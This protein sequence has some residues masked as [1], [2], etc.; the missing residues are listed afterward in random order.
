MADPAYPHGIFAQVVLEAANGIPRDGIVN[1]FHFSGGANPTTSDMDD[2]ATLLQSFYNTSHMT[3]E[4]A[5]AGW[6]SV[7]LSRGTNKAHV[8][9]YNMG[10]AHP[11]QPHTV[12][13]TLLAASSSD[14]GLPAEVSVCLS[15]Q[16]NANHTKS[17]RG[18]VYIGPLHSNT[19][20]I[21]SNRVFPAGDTIESIRGAARF[22]IDAGTD[23][24]HPFHWSIY[25]RKLNEMFR[26]DA[27]YVDNEFDTQ[28]RRGYRP[29][30][31]T[32]A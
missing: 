31:R 10:D 4:P 28:R 9:L 3:S 32:F 5:I 19:V 16:T 23:V 2:V 11:R 15:L 18:R 13:F 17:G 29:T 25:S 22:L 27:A 8:K 26:V 24:S 30:T 1:G 6:L 21:A 7:L 20:R 12:D 14:N